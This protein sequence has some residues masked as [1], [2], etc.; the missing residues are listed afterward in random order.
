MTYE[1]R[2]ATPAPEGAWRDHD[3]DDPDPGYFQFD[4]LSG[5]HPDLYH[6]FALTSVALVEQLT[7]RF[8]LSGLI[9]AEIAAGTAAARSASPVTPA[10]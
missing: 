3:V 10:M 8:D 2:Y 7:Q 6:A 1:R 9:V 4:W 5:R